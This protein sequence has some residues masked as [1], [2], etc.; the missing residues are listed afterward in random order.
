MN[1]RPS[2]RGRGGAAWRVSTTSRRWRRDD[3]SPHYFQPATIRPNATLDWCHRAF[4]GGPNT[5]I[6]PSPKFQ[7][8]RRVDS[9]DAP[10]RAV[11]WFTIPAD[12][13]RTTGDERP[14]VVFRQKRQQTLDLSGVR[15]LSDAD[16]MKAPHRQA[17]TRAP[18]ASCPRAVRFLWNEEMQSLP[19][20]RTP[21]RGSH[22]TIF[23]QTGKKSCPTKTSKMNS[24]AFAAKMRP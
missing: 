18:Q 13:R 20:R 12:L 10:P 15:P 1:S 4:C 17:P 3:D 19:A 22:A 16:R 2:R 23:K 11:K 24:S 7:R 5:F 14:R 9:I 8:V 21:Q 6:S